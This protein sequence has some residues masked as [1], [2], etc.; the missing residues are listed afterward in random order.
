[1]RIVVD[2]ITPGENEVN[3][4]LLVRLSIHDYEP[5]WCLLNLHGSL[6]SDNK[7]FLSVGE[8]FAIGGLQSS[9]YTEVSDCDI[10]VLKLTPEYKAHSNSILRFPMDERAFNHI[11][12]QRM[13]NENH[14]VILNF[15]I[16][17]R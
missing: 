12:E 7:T 6:F 13:K 2:N 11:N 3:P 16:N 4:S 14:D 9:P 1:M 15:L 10:E 5:N 8:E 17:L